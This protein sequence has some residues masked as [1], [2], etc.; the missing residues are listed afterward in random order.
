MADLSS[1]SNKSFNISKS[2]SFLVSLVSSISFF[3]FSGSITRSATSSSCPNGEDIGNE[4]DITT[5]SFVETFVYLAWLLNELI[6]FFRLI[7]KIELSSFWFCSHKLFNKAASIDKVLFLAETCSVSVL[8]SIDSSVVLAVVVVVVDDSSF[9][10]FSTFFSS[11]STIGKSLSVLDSIFVLVV[12]GSEISSVV[13]LA[14]E[15]VENN[16]SSSSEVVEVDK[17]VVDGDSVVVVVVSVVVVLVVGVVV[18][19]VVVVGNSVVEV[20]SVVVVVEVE[21]VVVVVVVVDSVVV[22]VVDVVVLV[23]VEVGVVI[24]K[25]VVVGSVVVVV[26]DSVVVVVGKVVVVLVLVVVGV[27]VLV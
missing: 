27:V 9:S 18:L 22:V 10:T 13:S 11:R 15:L 19:V 16:F 7:F 1:I 6:G 23:L 4:V 25:V 24:N 26:V 21:V 14:I 2:L 5:G 17:V 8:V 20:V 3:I 12:V